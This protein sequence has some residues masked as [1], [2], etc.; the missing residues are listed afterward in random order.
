[1]ALGLQADYALKEAHR[2]FGKAVER[3]TRIAA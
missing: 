2:A 1:M 3:I